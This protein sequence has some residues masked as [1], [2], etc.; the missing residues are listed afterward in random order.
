MTGFYIGVDGKAR[1]VKGCYIG[2]DG[3][4]RKV[5]KG[6][7][8]D[9]NG[10]ARLCYLDNP[11]DPVFANNSWEDVIAAC[12]TGSVPDSWNVGDQM[13]MTIDGTDY[14]I[15]II[16]KNH[17]DYSD[18]SGKAPL[19]FQLHD[20][21]KT[22]YPMNGSS[23]NKWDTCELRTMYLPEILSKMPTEVRSAIRSVT[24]TTTSGYQNT[25]KVQTSDKLFLLSEIEIFGSS[26]YSFGGEGTRY[27]YY[28]KGN[29]PIKRINNA[30][31]WWW[32]RSPYSGNSADFV[33]IGSEGTPYVSGSASKL[34][35]SFA[36]CF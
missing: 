14:V 6:Y 21:Y 15:D 35:V 16:G 8:G 34:G 23:S 10:V 27:E 36:F 17:D 4:A 11:Y 12:Q 9:E 29:S 25:S 19:T 28:T 13:T 31:D 7:I 5:K 22:K 32:S 18:G 26:V 2:I 33:R 20:C 1:K 24:K 30:I 3:V